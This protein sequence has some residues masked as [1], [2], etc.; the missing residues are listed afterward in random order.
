MLQ[1][2]KEWTYMYI[3]ST[4]VCGNYLRAGLILFSKSA[5]A[6]TILG[7][8]VIK[9]IWYVYLLYMY[10]HNYMYMYVPTVFGLKVYVHSLSSA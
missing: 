6:G 3:C 5:N 8:E 9:E 10:L 1:T 7:R 2:L 4:W